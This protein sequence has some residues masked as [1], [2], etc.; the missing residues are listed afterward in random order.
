MNLCNVAYTL[1]KASLPSK[2]EETLGSVHFGDLDGKENY[3][4]RAYC[5]YVLKVDSCFKDRTVI[6]LCS[7]LVNMHL[8]G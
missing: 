2:K 1:R 6:I 5:N 8:I 7:V 3:L 4:N